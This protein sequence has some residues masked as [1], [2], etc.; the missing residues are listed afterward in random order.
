M[1]LAISAVGE[2][3][4]GAANQREA[5]ASSKGTRVASCLS[6]PSPPA[7]LRASPSAFH[8]DAWFALPI[9]YDSEPSSE[10]GEKPYELEALVLARAY[11]PAVTDETAPDASALAR[12]STTRARSARR[13][14]KPCASIRKTITEPSPPRA[15]AP[16]AS[17]STRAPMADAG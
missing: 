7:A 10:A 1:T 15:P 14:H 11:W 12:S 4:P 9:Q 8:I 3:M 17:S 16:R 2:I 13:S 6:A 5:S